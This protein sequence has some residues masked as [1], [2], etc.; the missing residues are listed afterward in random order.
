[1]REGEEE[2]ESS[3]QAEPPR[4]SFSVSQHSFL[5]LSPPPC[6]FTHPHR[7]KLTTP[8]SPP[9][10]PPL[11]ATS[12]DNSVPSRFTSSCLP[13]ATPCP[14]TPSALSTPHSTSLSPSAPHRNSLAPSSSTP[15]FSPLHPLAEKCRS[16]TS[17]CSHRF[18]LYSTTSALARGEGALDDSAKWSSSA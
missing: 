16:I 8:A 9:L 11:P 14:P 4:F 10:R 5:S 12:V 1:M 6:C 7:A 13:P 17:Q 2:R 15:R 18:R 3:A